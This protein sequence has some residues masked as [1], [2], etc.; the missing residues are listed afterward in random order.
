MLLQGADKQDR[1]DGEN[2][3][4]DPGRASVEARRN[5]HW[6]P[7]L[8]DLSGRH[9]GGH[10]I[11]CFGCRIAHFIKPRAG[12]R[13][14]EPHVRLHI[15]LRH[16]H[17]AGVQST[18]GCLCEAVHLVGGPCGTTFEAAPATGQQG[19]SRLRPQPEVTRG[20][21][22]IAKNFPILSHVRTSAE[23]V[24]GYLGPSLPTP[25]RSANPCAT[26]P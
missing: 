16:A 6:S 26:E 1:A 20:G 15:V 12:R 10:F 18:E 21:L 9:L 13:Q 22:A 19:G 4:R 24:R 8:R 25:S 3:R 2:T 11:A 7:R 17:A 5:R 23:F 14:I